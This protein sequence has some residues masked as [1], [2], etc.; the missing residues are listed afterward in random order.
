MNYLSDSTARLNWIY[1]SPKA[2]RK[3][4]LLI[5]QYNENSN[6][7][8][9][10]R[11]LY[12]KSV[13]ANYSDEIDV[14]LID[15]GSTDDSLEIMKKFQEAHDYPFYLASV[16][17]NCNKVGALFLTILSISHEFVV[18]SDFDTDIDGYNNIMLQLDILRKEEDSMGCY[19][20]MLPFE[21]AGPVFAF[22]QLEYAILRSLYRFYAK[23]GSV[24]VMPGAGACYKRAELLAIYREHSGLRSGED[25]EATMIG[26]KLGYRTYY[27]EE[28]LT[29]TRPPLSFKTLSKQRVRWNLGYLETFYKEKKYYGEQ[30][31]RFT[32][33]GII[34]L[35][36][37]LIVSFMLLLP[38]ILLLLGIMNV[39][40]LLYFLLGIFIGGILFC[41]Y[42][43]AVCPK[44]FIELR[45]KV[46]FP[47]LMFLPFK[48]VVGHITWV[49]AL[50]VFLKKAKTY[51]FKFGLK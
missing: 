12:F 42:A 44:E 28:V 43:I 33:I 21:G 16:T 36:D 26:L 38:L 51:S 5:P 11:L 37:I 47:I 48:L 10:E 30:I 9:N 2:G 45:G 35:T 34:F 27:Q 25:R 14:I 1:A 19:F 15:D 24:P 46:L 4:A 18:L 20:R 41:L 22:Q 40:I 13:A 17:P 8:F 39:Y 32:R 29:L 31:K 50:L 23:E 7:D 3:T 49:K 6:C